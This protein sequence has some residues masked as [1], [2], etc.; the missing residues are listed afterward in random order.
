MIFPQTTHSRAVARRGAAVVLILTSV[1]ACR[2]DPAAR[3][4]DYPVTVILPKETPLDVHT[5]EP[6]ASPTLDW[7]SVTL[8]APLPTEPAETSVEFGRQPDPLT[9]AHLDLLAAS[10]YPFELSDAEMSLGRFVLP[11]DLTA[12]AEQG[13]FS[14]RSIPFNTDPSWRFLALSLP[15]P[16]EGELGPVIRAP[17]SGEIM[18]GSFLMINQ[19]TVEVVNIDHSL[20]DDQLLRATLVY[21]GTI[22]PL[23]TIRQQVQAGEALFRLTRGSAQLDTLAGTPIPGGAILTVHA[24]IDTV[25]VEPSG[26]ERLDF[27]RSVSL[28]PAG[29]LR[30]G[31]GLIVSPQS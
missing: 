9:E 16:D 13:S 1:A 11:V 31:E 10:S 3:T 26:L 23:F 19:Q 29:F 8:L 27:V 4:P 18:A 25:T 2:S 21:T 20:G 30:D 24:S 17:I 14:V 12:L 5:P 7:D 28:T 22:E 6:L 15:R